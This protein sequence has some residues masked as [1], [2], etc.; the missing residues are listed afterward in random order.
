MGEVISQGQREFEW[1]PWGRLLKV[2]DPT[3]TWEASYDA[4]GRRLE[5]RHTPTNSSTVRTTNLYDPEE[6][7]QEI[8]VKQGEKTY[9]KLYGP[10]SLDAILDETE[11]PIFLIYNALNELVATITEQE[12]YDTPQICS[13]Y[14]PQT[15]P[16]IPSDL[17]S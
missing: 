10:N 2:T 8:G 11:T 3:F 6:E 5:T 17:L 1:D 12:T 4:L 13:S 14:G 16:S 9:W 15:E 7:F